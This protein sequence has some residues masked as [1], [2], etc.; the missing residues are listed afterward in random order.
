[1]AQE[2]NKNQIA[3][4]I[5]AFWSSLTTPAWKKDDLV[6]LGKLAYA[7]VP[8]REIDPALFGRLLPYF[9]EISKHL[10]PQ[11]EEILRVEKTPEQTSPVSPTG[12]EDKKEEA[13]EESHA[14]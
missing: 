13:P 5:R 8:L 9:T 14:K 10:Y 11:I 7:K 3:L 12:Q 6:E 2:P 1:M 4:L